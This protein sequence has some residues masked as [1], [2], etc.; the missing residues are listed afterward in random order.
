M[1]GKSVISSTLESS[2]FVKKRSCSALQC[3]VF[4]SLEPGT[5]VCC[6]HPDIVSESLFL[7]FQTS[8]LT[9]FL[10]WVFLTVFNVSENQGGQLRWCHTRRAQ[11]CGVSVRKFCTESIVLEQ[12]LRSMLAAWPWHRESVT[13]QGVCGLNKMHAELKAEANRLGVD[14]FLGELVGGVH[15]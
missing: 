11:G 1:S 13:R 10:L 3:S 8:I 4:R 7:S 5:H 2:D 12:I 15:C 9:S 14:E 6:L